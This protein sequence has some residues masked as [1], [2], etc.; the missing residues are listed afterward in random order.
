MERELRNSKQDY[1]GNSKMS[2]LKQRH[3][4]G[5]GTSHEMTWVGVKDRVRGHC[6]KV[7]GF[8]DMTF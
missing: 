8:G 3:D 2:I 5:E 6:G 4:I 1:W 7:G